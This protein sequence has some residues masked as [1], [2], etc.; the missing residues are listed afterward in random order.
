MGDIEENV[1]N[2]SDSEA[3]F[4]AL[5]TNLM[6]EDMNEREQGKVAM[7]RTVEDFRREYQTDYLKQE[8]TA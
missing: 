7:L 2:V 8:L 1:V 5:K 6:R 4:L 3:L